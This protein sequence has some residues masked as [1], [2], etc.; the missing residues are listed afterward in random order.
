MTIKVIIER[1]VKQENKE[2]LLS[3]LTKLREK[4]I[5]QTGYISGETLSSLDNPGTHVVI[6]TW[7]ILQ[8]WR[9][10]EKNQER[11]VLIA[12]ID[13]LLTAPARAGVFLPSAASLTWPDLPEGV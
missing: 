6:S 7:N 12:L 4:A 10:W 8:D 11:R 9:T 2:P 1:T 5:H 3:L 13:N